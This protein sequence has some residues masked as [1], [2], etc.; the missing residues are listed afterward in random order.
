[1]ENKK[2]DYK[3][4]R[5]NLYLKYNEELDST[6]AFI[7]YALLEEQEKNFQLQN[8]KLEEATNKINNSQRILQVSDNPKS[9]AFAFAFGL[10][11]LSILTIVLF[12]ASFYW[13]HLIDLKNKEQLSAEFL[14]YKAYFEKAENKRLRQVSNSEKQ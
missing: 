5:A 11:G 1:M 9:Q 10:V 14:Y 4:H 6:S 2:Y 8:K 12:C 7:L 3:S 13:Y